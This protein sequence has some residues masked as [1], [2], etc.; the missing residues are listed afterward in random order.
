MPNYIVTY[1]E[2]VPTETDTIEIEGAPTKEEAKER[3]MDKL[4]IQLGV[5]KYTIHKVD[6]KK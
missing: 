5:G 6:E 3:A 1:Y 4:D 2:K